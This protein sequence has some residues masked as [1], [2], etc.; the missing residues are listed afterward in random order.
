MEDNELM[1]VDVDKIRDDYENCVREEIYH[2]EKCDFKSEEMKKVKEHFMTIHMTN[3]KFQCWECDKEIEKVTE[4]KQHFG[5]Y[6][7]TP[8]AEQ[9][10][11][12]QSLL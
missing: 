6:H 9:E 7:Y 11:Q 2:C 8:I 12:N 5:S 1:G 3:Y 4:L 10:E